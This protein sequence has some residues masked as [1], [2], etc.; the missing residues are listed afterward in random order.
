MVALT[1]DRPRP[2]GFDHPSHTLTALRPTL[3]Q[4]V[5]R[6]P[7]FYPV[8]ARFRSLQVGI[9]DARFHDYGHWNAISYNG[10]DAINPPIMRPTQLFD[11]LFDVPPN[12]E[13]LGRRSAVLDA[14]L[15]DARA[16]E[17]RLGS[18]DR[19]RLQSHVEHIYEIQNRLAVAGGSCEKPPRP[20]DGGDLL[21]RTATMAELLALA[22]SCGQTRVVSFML[23]SPATT[24]VFDNL[25]A[26]DGM[27]K[28]CHD[29]N[30]DVV[31]N[32]AAHQ[33]EAFALFLDAFA[34]IDHPAGGTLLDRGCVFGTS[35]Y[36]EGYFHSVKEFPAILAGGACGRMNA[37]VHVREPDGNISKVHL[38]ILRALGLPFDSF[39]FNGGQTSDTLGGMLA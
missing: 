23:T 2:E 10:P 15:D 3:D 13:E 31:R 29:G 36:G 25:G 9:S 4:V 37:G 33:M 28:V 8:P 32:I 39:G 24:H 21:A 19:E 27:H 12:V 6:H 14:V 35:E 34:G 18:R 30:W 1:A 5:A 16:L 38:T 26:P 17:A 11:L 22:V 7:M 20:N